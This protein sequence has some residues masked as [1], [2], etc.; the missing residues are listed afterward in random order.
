MQVIHKRSAKMQVRIAIV[1]LIL[2][3]FILEYLGSATLI[4]GS[5]EKLVFPVRVSSRNLLKNLETPFFT[6]KRSV[7]SARKVQMLE[8]R[9][10]EA[11]AQLA[12]L[13]GLRQ[14][15]EELRQLLENSDRQDREVVIAAPIV[16]NL[17]PTVGA[18]LEDG[19][20]VGDLV[21]VSK[22]LVG[23]I[24]K[25]ETH[26]SNV[27]LLNQKDS[28]PQVVQTDEGFR[29]VVKGDGK[30]IILTEI[31][32]DE[33]PA[34][35]SKILTVGQIGVEPGIFVGQVGK[36]LS[37]PSDPVKTY[38]LIQYVDFYQARVVEIYK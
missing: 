14:E 36:L 11:L 26:F 34:Q 19:V 6:V 5:L 22:T 24:S 7:N 12:S 8:A 3:L 35:E 1:G 17:G 38:A 29:G 28:I 21:F 9:Y 10:S 4:S 23:R 18:G 2:I 31:L 27:S 13:D 15:N 37:S 16:S 25:V 32:P 33:E 20:E 30:R